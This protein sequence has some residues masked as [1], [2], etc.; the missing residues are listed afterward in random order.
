MLRP[1][2][3]QQVP[4]PA[5]GA[6]FKFT[7]SATD[8]C[9]LLVLTCKLLTSAAAGNRS[10]I[11]E[12][13]DQN[14]L[15][16]AVAPTNTNLTATTTTVITWAQGAALGVKSGTATEFLSVGLMEAWMHPGDSVSVSGIGTLDAADQFSQIVARY[17]SR[18]HWVELQRLEHLEVA[19]GS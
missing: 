1:S 19:L 6:G 7:P 17:I 10:V 14:G 9:K 8:S 5:A 3:T 12:V 4:Q 16:V 11:L 18:E 15:L 13:E 2:L